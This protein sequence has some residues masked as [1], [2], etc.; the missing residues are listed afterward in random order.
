MDFMDFLFKERE[1]KRVTLV[2]LALSCMLYQE[3]DQ[4]QRL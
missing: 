3:L 2:L 4:L 1:M